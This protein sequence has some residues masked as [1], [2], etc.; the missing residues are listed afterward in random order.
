[1][2][3]TIFAMIFVAFILHF[4]YPDPIIFGLVLLA[5]ATLGHLIARIFEPE[6]PSFQAESQMGLLGTG[7]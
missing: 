7:T 3:L 6:T 5:I 4:A 1:M 2:S